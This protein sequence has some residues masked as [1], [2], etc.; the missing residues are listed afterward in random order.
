[1]FESKGLSLNSLNRFTILLKPWISHLRNA[2]YHFYK[3]LDR[4][5]MEGGFG[6]YVPIF[7]WLWVD[8]W[9]KLSWYPLESGLFQATKPCQRAD[10][11]SSSEVHRV[12]SLL[13]C[14]NDW[15]WIICYLPMPVVQMHGILA[16]GGG[17]KVVFLSPYLRKCSNLTGL[18]KW[19]EASNQMGR[20]IPSSPWWFL[21]FN[22]NWH[23]F[24]QTH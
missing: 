7:E 21:A 13:P 12:Q 14:C 11:L 1:M 9:V 3:A 20:P 8:T 19:L 15:P 2:K 6:W 10:V 18:L 17:F 24:T 4:R 16:I 22:N 23:T 5:K